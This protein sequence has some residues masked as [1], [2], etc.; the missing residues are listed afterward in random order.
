MVYYC[1]SDI[2]GFINL[3]VLCFCWGRGGYSKLWFPRCVTTSL[4]ADMNTI[5]IDMI[6]HRCFFQVDLLPH[7]FKHN[8][9][10]LLNPHLLSVTSPQWPKVKRPA[11]GTSCH[12]DLEKLVDD[13]SGNKHSV[14]LCMLAKGYDYS[15]NKDPENLSDTWTFGQDSRP[16]NRQVIYCMGSNKKEL[17]SG[18]GLE[19]HDQK[20]GHLCNI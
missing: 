20:A 15:L 4:I 10:M 3:P 5:C 18:I 11:F 9:L 8:L 2:A 13:L 14:Q 1:F 6:M 7:W 17:R 19:E 12:L 16:A